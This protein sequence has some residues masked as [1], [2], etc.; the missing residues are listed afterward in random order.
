MLVSCRAC[1]SCYSFPVLPAISEMCCSSGQGFRSV[2]HAERLPPHGARLRAPARWGA[3]E[4]CLFF[5][6]NLASDEP[7]D[8]LQPPMLRSKLLGDSGLPCAHP[9]AQTATAAESQPTEAE[10]TANYLE[11]FAFLL[12]WKTRCL[13]T[14]SEG[15][16]NVSKQLATS[17][18]AAGTLLA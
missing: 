18:V 11:I 5:V 3:A 10:R 7:Q 13:L 17:W 16:E 12:R 8:G 15:R 1:C 14:K 2:A 6:E 4:R 9:V